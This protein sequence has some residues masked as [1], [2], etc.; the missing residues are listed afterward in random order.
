LPPTSFKDLSILELLILSVFYKLEIVFNNDLLNLERFFKGE[1]SANGIVR[2]DVLNSSFTTNF[3]RE[4]LRVECRTSKVCLSVVLNRLKTIFKVK[5]NW[6]FF[7][8]VMLT[9]KN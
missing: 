9:F 3:V 7:R 4:N 5:K 6:P 2:I 8:P 1:V